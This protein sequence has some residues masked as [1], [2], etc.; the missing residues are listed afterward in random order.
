MNVE[1][2]QTKKQGLPRKPADYDTLAKKAEHLPYEE[3]DAL[4]ER[5]HLSQ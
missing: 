3:L 1:P 5:G 4:A 2:E